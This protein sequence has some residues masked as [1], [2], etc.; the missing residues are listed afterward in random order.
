VDKRRKQLLGLGH[1]QHRSYGAAVTHLHLVCFAY[2]LLT[3]LR[4]ARPG[5]QGEW[6]C[7][8]A[9]DL[10]TAAAQDQL[11]SLL[12]EDLLTYLQEECPD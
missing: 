5:A 12:W 2:A 1:Y 10:S 3:R 8:K 4:I 6:T 9:A 11:W 7:Q